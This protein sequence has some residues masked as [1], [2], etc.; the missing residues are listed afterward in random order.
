VQAELERRGIATA[1]I[2]ML[3]DITRAVR[4]P[5]ALAVPWKLGYPL[6]AAGDAEL[7]TRVVRRLLA[8]CTRTDV[9]V[10]DDL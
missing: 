3:P 2:T 6:G 8:L 4:P 9:P 10:I 1:S 7:Q 5:R